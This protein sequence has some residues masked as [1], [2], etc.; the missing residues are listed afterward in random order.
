MRR[1]VLSLLLILSMVLP[2][3]TQAQAADNN[4]IYANAT[5]E[6]VSL[7]TNVSACINDM[8]EGFYSGLQGEYV[9]GEPIPIY[10]ADI[11][12]TYY[13]I[14]V[15]CNQQCVGTIEVDTSGNAVLSDDVSL[16][17]AVSE[18][19]SAEH[20]LYTT[21]GVTYAEI[22]SERIKL[23]ECDFVVLK[24]DSFL[25]NTYLSKKEEI[26]L[27][28]EQARKCIDISA[29]VMQSKIINVT[30]N[31]TR[32][33][34]PT[35]VYEQCAIEDFVGQGVRT[36]CWAACTATIVNYKKNLELTAEEIS[37]AMGHDNTNIFGNLGEYAD[38]IIEALAMY[39]VS[40]RTTN[41]KLSWANVKSNINNDD[42]FI[43]GMTGYYVNNSTLAD[44]YSSHVYVGYG[45]QHKNG[46]SAVDADLRYVQAWDPGGHHVAF[47]HNASS[48]SR[49]GY[50]WTWEKTIID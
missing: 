24:N 4:M 32:G 50:P 39:N 13:I 23:Y 38:G 45:Y 44:G 10:N 49:N 3:C 27:K 6:K 26:S 25:L 20:L 46:D 7:E 22:P 36:I 33:V 19:T 42:P 12:S 14:P 18:I 1:R 2:L 15:L 30:E 43:I 5:S 41:G 28:S 34:T 16:Y 21:G 48:Y 47:Q 9:I 8:I 11:K 29:V 35:V 17:N 40:Y 37:E 31:N